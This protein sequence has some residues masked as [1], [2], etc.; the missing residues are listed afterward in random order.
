MKQHDLWAES[1]EAEKPKQNARRA[2]TMH[3]SRVAVLRKWQ[4]IF[5]GETCEQTTQEFCESKG[6]SK[7]KASELL[8]RPKA[9]EKGWSHLHPIHRVIEGDAVGWL[10]R[11]KTFQGS[12]SFQPKETISKAWDHV[13]LILALYHAGQGIKPIAKRFD[14]TPLS[15][16]NV[17]RESGINTSDRANY[18]RKE[19][20][21]IV[22]KGRNYR[23]I[24]AD[25][26]LL[27]KKRTMARIW[28]AMKRQSVNARG[29]FSLVGCTADQLRDH[30]ASMFQAGMTFENYGEWHVDHIK[31]CASFDLSDPKQMAECFNWRNLQPLWAKENLSKGDR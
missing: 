19:L 25:P 13:A 9:N 16:W 8:H 4:N 26:A 23:R 3:D 2:R 29:S 15:V 31:P 6:I 10:I 7:K 1:V 28:K 27:I 12:K 24:K 17:L 20:K 11:R 18:Q 21:T 5:T 30:I 22:N 14:L